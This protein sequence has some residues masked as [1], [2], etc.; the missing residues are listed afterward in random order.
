MPNF[1][2][3]IT[4]AYERILRRPADPAGIETYNRLMNS[5]MSESQMRETLLRSQEY[6]QNNPD[7]SASAKAKP[8]K[9]KR[10]TKG[11]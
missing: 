9:A 8:K 5:G 7:R 1:G 2:P 3:V 10:R 4:L 6:A 11:R